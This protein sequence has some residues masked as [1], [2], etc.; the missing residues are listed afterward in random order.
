MN[1][2]VTLLSDW[3]LR[4]PYVAMLK[5]SLLKAFPDAQILDITHYV[6][7][8]N[9]LQTAL[10]M[11]KCY[12]S[13]PDG[14][15][16]LILT[17]MSLNDTFSPVMLHHDGHYFI[18][19]DNGIFHL[20][21]GQESFLKGFQLIENKEN[22]LKQILGLIQSVREESLA[23]N[24]TEYL[25]FKRM[26]TEQAEHSAQEKVIEGQIVYIDAFNNA[27]TNIPSKMF[28]DTVK[29]KRF[30]ATI[31]SKGS[32]NIQRYY[33]Q[34]HDSYDEMYLCNN[35]LGLI[36]VSLYKSDVAVLADLEPGDKILISYE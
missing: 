28:A 35:A 4:D 24:T 21:F 6:D 27:V 7:K 25:K 1:L 18:G 9:L 23:N 20:M 2:I 13:F 22:T 17:N 26:F 3:R 14:S 33:E 30:T 12:R 16:H 8:F 36:E 31:Q 15:I 29:G 10:L 32:W 11:K 19:E 34:Y 5:G